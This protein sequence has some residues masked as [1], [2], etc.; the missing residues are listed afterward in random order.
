MLETRKQPPGPDRSR[1]VSGL[2]RG[3]WKDA[4]NASVTSGEGQHL[5]DRPRHLYPDGDS[6]FLPLLSCG[7]SQNYREGKNRVEF[8]L[9]PLA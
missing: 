3:P 6:L 5:Q 7:P 9:A 2:S 4:L 1:R 8:I